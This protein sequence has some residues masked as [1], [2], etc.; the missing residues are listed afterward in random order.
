MVNSNES[1]SFDELR[2][3]KRS[4]RKDERWSKSTER[5]KKSKPKKKKRDLYSDADSSASDDSYYRDRKRRK[6]ERSKD[7]KKKKNKKSRRKHRDADTTS[8]NDDNS[9]GRLERNHTLA[10]ALCSLFDSHPALASDL[11]VMLIRL[12]G[13]GSFD[14]SQMTDSGAAHGLALVFACLGP[15]GVEQ[16]GSTW[17]W[18]NPSGSSSSRGNELV[19]L[20]VVRAML[21]QIGVTPEAVKRFEN[22]PATKPPPVSQKEAE[23]VDTRGA[24]VPDSEVERKTTELLKLFREGD[25]A[26]ELAGL[27]KMILAGEVIALDGLPDEQLRDALESLFA[28][29][30]LEKS[31]MEVDS[32]EEDGGEEVDASIG[33]GLPER[34]DESAKVM[35]TSVLRVC[36]SKPPASLSRRPIEGPMLHPQAYDNQQYVDDEKESSDDDEGP[37]PAGASAKARASTL[38]NEMVKAVAARRARELACA[39]QGIELDPSD[40]NVRE[41]WMLVPGKFDFLSAIKSGQPIRSRQFETKSKAEGIGPERQVDPSIQAEIRAIR[42]AHEEARGPSL[43]E[44]HREMKKAEAS[45]KQQGG[46]DAW[47]WNRDND[48]DAGR[49]VDKDALNMIMGGA[50]SDLKNK[51]QSSL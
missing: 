12:A 5:R 36:H 50:S 1:I 9:T 15:F 18:K 22:P 4:S 48:L 16:D 17:V 46:T 37:L 33:Y 51:F 2:D 30:G 44:Q 45:K 3:R 25:L 31:E 42:Q 21:D 34:N 40:G 19:L 7:K 35:L 24:E 47:K 43:M 6:K 27:C 38:S 49:R 10:T 20:R 41:E 11:P 13:G 29:C 23:R 39:K 14:L 32:D 28:S 8:S 26:N